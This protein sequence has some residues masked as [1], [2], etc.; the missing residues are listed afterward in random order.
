MAHEIGFGS[1]VTTHPLA[2]DKMMPG[3]KC[4]LVF[5]AQKDLLR[6]LC[7]HVAGAAPSVTCAWG[8]RGLRGGVPLSLQVCYQREGAGGVPERPVWGAL[9]G[10]AP[11]GPRL[12]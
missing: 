12:Q 8:L 6:E 1:K 10:V 9:E 11:D 7:L 3:S 4:M 5:N 2:K